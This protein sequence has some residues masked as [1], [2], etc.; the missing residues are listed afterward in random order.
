MPPLV[1]AGGC[2]RVVIKGR[3]G[4]EH[5]RDR[6]HMT[7]NKVRNRNERKKLSNGEV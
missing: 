4:Q 5:G 2:H 3:A 7:R 1:V 6:T